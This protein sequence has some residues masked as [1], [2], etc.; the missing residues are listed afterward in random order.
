MNSGRAWCHMPFNPNIGETK[1]GGSWRVWGQPG[2]FRE[3]ASQGHIER[4]YLKTKQKSNTDSGTEIQMRYL[5]DCS[6]C[7]KG[8][9]GWS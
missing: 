5:T 1:A 8:M 3:K 2:L 4:P 6:V 9:G 7:P